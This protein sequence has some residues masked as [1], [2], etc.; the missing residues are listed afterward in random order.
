MSCTPNTFLP[1][2]W[3]VRLKVNKVLRKKKIAIIYNWNWCF[4]CKFHISKKK[5][6]TQRTFSPRAFPRAT[7]HWL[8]N[9]NLHICYLR[10]FFRS[11]MTCFP[12][13]PYAAPFDVT[14]WLSIFM[15]HRVFIENRDTD[16]A[17]KKISLETIAYIYRLDIHL[18]ERSR[19][20]SQ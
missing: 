9:K 17:D 16:Y 7:I 10:S 18:L 3:L 15:K 4:F 8:S 1:F 5:A 13:C 14:T 20:R 6:S 2:N 11:L 19:N 12:I